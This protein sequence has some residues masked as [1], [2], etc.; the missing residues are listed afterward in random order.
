MGISTLYARLANDTLI[1]NHVEEALKRHIG[2]V[3]PNGTIDNS[4]G[5]RSNK[6]TCFVDATSER[7]PY[8]I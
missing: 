6:W 4:W 2:F 3:Y 7:L 8:F 5:I 1:N